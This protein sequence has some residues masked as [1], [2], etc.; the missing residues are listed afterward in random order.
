[1]TTVRALKFVTYVD[2]YMRYAKIWVVL[3]K[4]LE[5]LL[6]DIISKI[7]VYIFAINTTSMPSRCFAT[8]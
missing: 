4:Q 1:M 7:I 3:L 6:V 5:V 8:R 2:V